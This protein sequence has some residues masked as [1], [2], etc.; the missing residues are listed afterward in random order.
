[1]L[2]AMTAGAAGI[3]TQTPTPEN[4]I[5]SADVAISDKVAGRSYSEP[6]RALMARSLGRVR[7]SL[8]AF[9][10]FELDN[11]LEPAI[12]FHPILPGAVVPK[13]GSHFRISKAPKSTSQRPGSLQFASAV[14][15]SRLLSAKRITSTE[16]TKF[17]LERLKKFGPRLN[18]VVNL[19]E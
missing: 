4:A 14:E 5:T 17:Y 11:R 7:D 1:T 18:C 9:R 10:E 13:G 3:R 2:G 19:T 16:L 15:L 6:E 12:L 8:M